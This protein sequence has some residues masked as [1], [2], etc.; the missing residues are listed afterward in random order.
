MNVDISISAKQIA[1]SATL[2]INELISSLRGRGEQ[3]YHMGFGESPF[4]VHELIREALCENS[5][6]QS[7]L[8]TQGV[9]QLRN[10]V[11]TFYKTVFNLEYSPEQIVVGP[12]SKSLMFAALTALDGPIFLPAPSWVS[13]QHIGHFLSR[14]VHHMI[15]N[16]KN[17]YRLEPELLTNALKEHAPNPNQQ[18]LLVLNYPCNPTGHSF[19]TQQ[20]KELVDVAQENN[21]IILSDE[22]YALTHFRDQEHHSIAEFYPEGT[23]ITGGL[24]K[25]RSLGG[26][27]LGV[28]LLP[29][30]ENHLL[31]TI[32][33]LGSEVWSS[34]P[35]PIQYAAIEAY[36]TDTG[37]VEYIKDC[38]TIHEVVTRYVYNRIHT[39]GLT[40]PSPQGAF[41]LFPDWNKHREVLRTKGITTSRELTQHLLENYHVSNLPGS[42][43]GMPPEDLCLRLATV[44]YKGDLALELFSTKRASLMENPDQYVASIAPSVV[45]GCNQ[46]E[47]FTSQLREE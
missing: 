3:V 6:R 29:E 42:E 23:L 9:L 45:E 17:S 31:R 8:P 7:Y 4:P 20:L 38:T 15:T 41:Y 18:K 33:A 2:A 11:S 34:A 30:D 16:S 26:Y 1:P 24:S 39:M 21:V 12:G 32:L 43:F 47:R 28:L 25:D 40:C 35:A 36:R 13:Y 22:I 27:R 10:Q 5:W 44:D 14:D 37:I 46:V 19:S